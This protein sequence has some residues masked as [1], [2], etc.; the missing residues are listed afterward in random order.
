MRK[1]IFISFLAS[2]IVNTIKAQDIQAI[3][4]GFPIE[5]QDVPYQVSIQNISNGNHFCGGSIINNKYVLTAAHCVN[6]KNASDIALNVGF[7]LQNNPGNNLQSYN[8]IRIVVHPNYSNGTNDFDVAI[9]EIDGTFSFNGSVQPV[10]LISPQSLASETIGNQVRVSGWGWTVPNQS[11]VANQLQAVD[12]PI[13]SNQQADNELDISFPNHPQLTQRMLSTGA[14]GMDRQGA[15]HGDSGGPLI[16]RQNGQNDIQIGVVSWGVPRCEGGENSSSIYARL[17][18]LEDWINGEAWNFVRIQGSNDVCYNSSK[19]F[20]I[21][22]IPNFINVINWQVSNNVTILSSN[23]SSITVRAKHSSSTGNGLVRATLSNGIV[24]QEDFN[25][26]VPNVSLI[27][28]ESFNS[29]PLATVTFTNI[30]ARYNWL[31]DVGQ[32]GYSW[33]WIVPSSQVIYHSPTYSYIHVSPL[34][35][36]TSIYIKTRACNECGPSEW[37]GKWF[38]VESPPS[39]C[40]DCPTRPGI[41][42]Y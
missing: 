11:G 14:V 21:Q 5:I 13:I 8:A 6:G 29:A 37:R 35:N 40:S 15:C 12:V 17:S 42:H 10:E 24:V 41:I 18:Q 4:N 34:G 38:T 33:E 19:T 36:L 16:F 39:G 2:I 32:L 1:I 7:S 20:T 25:V 26:G 23:N 27:T 9:I 28:L 31:I 22:N 3:T 30:T